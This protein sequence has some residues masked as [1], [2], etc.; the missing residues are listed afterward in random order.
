MTRATQLAQTQPEATPIDFVPQL[1]PQIWMGGTSILGFALVGSVIMNRLQVKKLMQRAK[2][3][4]Y[5]NHELKRKL[6]LALKTITQ[7]EHNPDL[8]DSR[9][10]NLDYLRLRMEEDRFNHYIVH[11]INLKIK[12]QLTLALRPQQAEVG[13][14]GIPSQ[15]RRVNET[16]DVEYDPSKRVS[17]KR[18]LFRVQVRLVKIPTQSTSQTVAQLTQ[19]IERYLLPAVDEENWYPTVQGRLLTMEW[20]QKAKPTPLLVIEQHQDGANVILSAKVAANR[21]H[22]TQDSVMGTKSSRNRGKTKIAKRQLSGSN[23]PK[24]SAP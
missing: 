21:I 6:K 4:H 15:S 20:D 12:R 17:T 23:R 2:F 13:E 18:V 19:C 11:Q 5:K 9:E 14:I 1:S 22:R 8:V 10:F 16:F 3:E 7:M 24:V